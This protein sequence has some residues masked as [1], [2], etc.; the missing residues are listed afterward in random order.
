[1]SKQTV[2]VSHITKLDNGQRKVQYH[3]DN[4]GKIVHRDTLTC[5]VDEVSDRMRV[6]AFSA[7]DGDSKL[8]WSEQAQLV[9]GDGWV[10]Q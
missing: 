4:N 7:M 10:R 9:D 6:I 1:M 8:Y 2:V 5:N 3:Y